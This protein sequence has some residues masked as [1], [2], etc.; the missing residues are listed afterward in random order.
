MNYQNAWGSKT[1]APRKPP[2]PRKR[3]WT[4]PGFHDPWEYNSIPSA[5]REW[6]ARNQSDLDKAALSRSIIGGCDHEED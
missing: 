5:D 3:G 4:P 1:Q 2:R 6:M